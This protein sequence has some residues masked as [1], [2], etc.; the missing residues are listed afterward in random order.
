MTHPS[1]KSHGHM[2]CD[3]RLHSWGC[4][5]HTSSLVSRM[6]K[7]SCYPCVCVRGQHCDRSTYRFPPRRGLRPH[8]EEASGFSRLARQPLK[9]TLHQNV[10]IRADCF[11]LCPAEGFPPSLTA[12]HSTGGKALLM[13]NQQASV[14]QGQTQHEMLL[15]QKTH[16]ITQTC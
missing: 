4:A 2:A 12:T 15:V 11:S 8:W 16:T 14:M 9:E 10:Q 1:H 6:L 13:T 7:G 3:I 5:S